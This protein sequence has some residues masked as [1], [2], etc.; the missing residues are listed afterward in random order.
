MSGIIL[1]L[2][3]AIFKPLLSL[4]WPNKEQKLEKAFK[5]EAGKRLTAEYK[6]KKMQMKEKLKF[7][8]DKIKKNREGMTDEEKWADLENDLSGGSF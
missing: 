5:K 8:R 7:N 6:I 4:I 1:G 3:S 2:L